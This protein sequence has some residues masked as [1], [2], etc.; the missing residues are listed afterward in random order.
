MKRIMNCK[1][2]FVFS[3]YLL[4]LC[5]RKIKICRCFA[6]PRVFRCV[7]CGKYIIDTMGIDDDPHYQTYDYIRTNFWGKPLR[8]KHNNLYNKEE[9]KIGSWLHDDNYKTVVCE[10]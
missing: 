2:D 3:G 8:R 6:P 10:L 9:F 5:G 7:N 4:E 1:H